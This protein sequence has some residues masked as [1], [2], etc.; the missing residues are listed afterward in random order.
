MSR[1][2]TQLKK[3]SPADGWVKGKLLHGIPDEN[4]F[5][6]LKIENDK[7]NKEN[8]E[9]RNKLLI[10]NSKFS[11]G[12]DIIKVK[13]DFKKQKK[14]HETGKFR[15]HDSGDDYFVSTWNDLYLIIANLIHHS[16]T[17]NMHSYLEEEIFDN[18]K[19]NFDNENYRISEININYEI[20]E[21]ILFQ[22]LT[23]KLIKK[24][25]NNYDTFYHFTPKGL[26]LYEELNAIK[27]Q[28]IVVLE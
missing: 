14:N 22:F 16:R 23:L 27:S 2:L 12:D 9:L 18:I 4:D 7:L 21:K 17:S 24:S 28:G 10:D 20:L 11:S 1:S 26:K 5:L 25:S 19:N 6:K 8:R 13:Y 15:N 3:Q